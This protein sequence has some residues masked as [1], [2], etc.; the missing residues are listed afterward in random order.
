MGVAGQVFDLSGQPVPNGAYMIWVTE[1][2]V[3][4]QTFAGSALAYGPSGWEVFLGQD[5][6]V[7]LNYRVQLFSPNGTP[8]SQ[9]Y[10]FT[11]TL[12]GSFH[13]GFQLLVVD[14][15]CYRYS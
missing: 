11:S 12:F 8:V 9:V 3:N 15:F 5:H 2:G 10:E 14:K 6:P 7:V 1:S 4:Q 13:N